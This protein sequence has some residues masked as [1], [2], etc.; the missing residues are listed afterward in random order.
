MRDEGIGSSLLPS[1][2]Q[3]YIDTEWNARLVSRAV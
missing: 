3:H 1:L 2:M